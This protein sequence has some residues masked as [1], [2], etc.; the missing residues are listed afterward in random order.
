MLISSVLMVCLFLNKAIMIASPI[1]ASAADTVIIKNTNACPLIV[2][3]NAEKAT[4][5]RFTE[6]SISSMH[7]NTI[8]AFRLVS[9]PI[10]PIVKRINARI[11]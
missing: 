8:I 1:A 3:R 4:K 11:R 9:T 10:T 7:I 6:L 5:T 2:P